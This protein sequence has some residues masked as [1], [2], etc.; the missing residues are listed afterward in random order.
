MDFHEQFVK[1]RSYNIMVLGDR[2]NT[3][4][5]YLEQFGPVQ[6]LSLEELFGY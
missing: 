1:G 3:P 2:K 6:E 4:L 5:S